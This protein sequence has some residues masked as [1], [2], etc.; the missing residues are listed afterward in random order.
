MWIF[1]KK[2]CSIL[3][4]P[5]LNFIESLISIKADKFLTEITLKLDFF[6]IIIDVLRKIY[7]ND[8][9]INKDEYYDILSFIRKLIQ[10]YVSIFKEPA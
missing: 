8:I 10:L 2:H 1:E 7:I 5:F 3:S 4:I 9:L 6:G